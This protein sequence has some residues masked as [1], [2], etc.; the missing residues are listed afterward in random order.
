M[1]VIV[2]AAE[3]TYSH[4]MLVKPRWMEGRLIVYEREDFLG[5]AGV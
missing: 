2:A 1:T 5:F 4:Q 3:V